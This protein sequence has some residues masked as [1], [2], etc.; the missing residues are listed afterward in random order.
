MTSADRVSRIPPPDAVSADRIARKTAHPPHGADFRT[1]PVIRH[2]PPWRPSDCLRAE[3]AIGTAADHRPNGQSGQADR[4]IPRAMS[5]QDRRHSVTNVGL[6]RGAR[7]PNPG[8]VSLAGQMGERGE[9]RQAL[10]SIRPDGV[11]LEGAGSLRSPP[12][13]PFIDGQV[14]RDAWPRAKSPGSS[15]RRRPQLAAS[16][17][18]GVLRVGARAGPARTAAGAVPAVLADQDRP[19]RRSVR[20]PWS[21]RAAGPGL[22]GMLAG[23][24]PLAALT[25][26]R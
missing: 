14:N 15:L 18:R 11:R 17:W 22:T 4:R 19:D 3:D 21:G 9:R 10:Q 26:C 6:R 2:R 16:C 25:L 13:A 5:D 24:S 8:A 7:S 1:P 20:W 23:V 12:I